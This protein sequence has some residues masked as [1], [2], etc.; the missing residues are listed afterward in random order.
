MPPKKVKSKKCGFSLKLH[1]HVTYF[2]CAPPPSW[3]V[4]KYIIFGSE[5]EREIERER[6]RERKR[7][8]SLILLHINKR[9]H[10][11]PRSRFN[12]KVRWFIN[13]LLLL[14]HKET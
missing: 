4:D 11:V 1:K 13:T 12:T 14:F 9:K 3:W 2:H 10:F 5:R 7:D 8:K 6:E